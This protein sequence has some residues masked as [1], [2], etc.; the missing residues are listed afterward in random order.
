MPSLDA[1]RR[2]A[3]IVQVTIQRL[4]ALSLGTLLVLG[5][6]QGAPSSVREEAS[7]AS[8]PQSASPSEPSRTEEKVLNFSNW[9]DYIPDQ[10]IERFERET[11]IKVNYKIYKSNEELMDRLSSGKLNDDIVVPSSNFGALQIEKGLL[12]PLDKSQLPNLTNIDGSMLDT[13]ERLDPGNRHLV[14][15][16]WGY[17][18]VGINAGKVKQALGDTPLPGNA[19]ELVFNPAYTSKLQQCGIGFLDSP[20]EI[21][22]AALHHIGKSPDSGRPEDL[23][24]AS[25]M[26]AKVRPHIRTLSTSLIEDLASGNLCVVLGWSGDI[27]LAIAEA[28]A[29]NATDIIRV[30]LPSTGGMLFVD[31]LAIPSNALHPRNAHAFINFFMRPD[32]AAMMSNGMSYPTGN[33]AAEAHIEPEVL[34]NRYIF[35]SDEEVRQLVPP[36]KLDLSL[37]IA[38]T[39]AYVQFAYGVGQTA[40]SRSPAATQPR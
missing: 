37:R 27:S 38:M 6:D 20:T 39:Q 7:A 17:T 4:V 5:C 10:L 8:S 30:L 21:I 19:W 14:P 32:V 24:A 1:L 34:A 16:A 18:T 26:L 22:P 13:L 15:W 29:S 9:P 33:K 35:L 40:D 3:A 12:R 11:G 36:P 2:T 23:Q 28:E 31:T 25:A